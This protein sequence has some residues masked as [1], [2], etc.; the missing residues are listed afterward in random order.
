MAAVSWGRTALNLETGSPQSGGRTTRAIL[1]RIYTLRPISSSISFHTPSLSFPYRYPTL[2]H[3]PALS[4]PSHPRE[5]LCQKKNL[6]H[7]ATVSYHFP[8]K[9]HF[10]ALSLSL[11]LSRVSRKNNPC[12]AWAKHIL[13]AYF[14]EI[15]H[16]PIDLQRTQCT[17]H[18]TTA[19]CNMRHGRGLPRLS[20]IIPPADILGPL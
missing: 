19:F 7:S 4:L 6:V 9:H 18:H 12:P 1:T 14:T 20:C 5:C 17:P 15:S 3:I 13:A 8:P 11:S 2:H 16:F 10:I